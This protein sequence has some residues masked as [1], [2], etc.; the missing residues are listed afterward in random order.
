MTNSTFEQKRHGL[1]DNALFDQN[2]W[3]CGENCYVYLIWAD[4]RF[5]SENGIG[6][7][8]LKVGISAN[9]DTRLSGFKTASP[10]RL[11]LVMT[12][13]LICRR[14]ALWV[15]SRFHSRNRRFRTSGEWFR[16]DVIGASSQIDGIIAEWWVEHYARDFGGA[17]EF[18]EFSG[19]PR[20]HSIDVLNALYGEE[21]PEID[22]DLE[23]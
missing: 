13:R 16:G 20:Q 9:P 5:H 21:N 11:E 6:D 10:F 12:R 23:A 14:D 3:E 7:S 17:V 8:L 19:S 2:A 4:A 18:L 1:N 22:E 15:E